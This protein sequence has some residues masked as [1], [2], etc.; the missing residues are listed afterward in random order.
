MP[1]RLAQSLRFFHFLRASSRNCAIFCSIKIAR[2]SLFSCHHAQ[3]NWHASSCRTASAAHRTSHLTRLRPGGS[4]LSPT[5]CAASSK[6]TLLS[7]LLRCD[8]A[9]QV[10]QR[11]CLHSQ[12]SA[13]LN[14]TEARSSTTIR[15]SPSLPAPAVSRL[16]VHCVPFCVA[17]SVIVLCILHLGHCLKFAPLF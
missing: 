3:Q 11:V 2:R 6:A 9:P 10:I 8:W 4:N 14:A 17:C 15:A 5:L 1:S 12:T 7:S 13:I 16:P